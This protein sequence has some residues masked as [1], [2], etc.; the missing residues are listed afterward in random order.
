MQY[1]AWREKKKD[2]FF[3]NMTE[4][5]NQKF[6]ERLTGIELLWV[7][8]KNSSKEGHHTGALQYS[9]TLSFYLPARA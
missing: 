1:K 7:L 5:Q 2:L 3:L 8:V 6:C 9:I 4:L